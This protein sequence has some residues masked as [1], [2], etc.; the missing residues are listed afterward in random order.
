M[1]GAHLPHRRQYIQVVG[2]L[3]RY[4]LLPGLLPGGLGL[5]AA[6]LIDAPEAEDERAVDKRRQEKPAARALK[7]KDHVQLPYT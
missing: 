2:G 4:H 6:R 3:E 7:A 5:P 1:G